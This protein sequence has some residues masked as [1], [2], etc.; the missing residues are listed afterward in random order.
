MHDIKTVGIMSKPG[1]PHASGIVPGLVQWLRERDIEVRCD[2]ETAKYLGETDGLSRRDVAVGSDLV[3][4]L[5]GDG[6]LLSAARAV[7]GR[8]IPILPVNLG[9]LGFLTAISQEEIFPEL[10]RTFRG[11]QRTVERR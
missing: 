2:K 5:G 6:T 9:G 7:N 4:V 1:I 10:E 3:I 8:H 11:E